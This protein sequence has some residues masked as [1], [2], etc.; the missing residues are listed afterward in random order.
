M[1]QYSRSLRPTAPPK[2]RKHV[3]FERQTVRTAHAD[4]EV[5]VHWARDEAPHLYGITGH[6]AAPMLLRVERLGYRTRSFW[7]AGWSW[8]LRRWVSVLCVGLRF[9]VE[10]PATGAAVAIMHIKGNGL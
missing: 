10:V 3:L 9:P 7:K 5:A 6:D 8:R 1:P 2:R 4:D